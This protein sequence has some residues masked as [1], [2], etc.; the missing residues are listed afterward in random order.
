MFFLWFVDSR[1]FNGLKRW[2]ARRYHSH[3]LKDSPRL[4]ELQPNSDWLSFYHSWMEDQES[5]QSLGCSCIADIADFIIFH[6]EWKMMENAIEIEVKHLVWGWE[7]VQ[8][9]MF[10]DLGNMFSGRLLDG[11][12]IEF[13]GIGVPTV[14]FLPVKVVSLVRVSNHPICI[15]NQSQISKYMVHWC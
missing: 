2:S 9:D 8:R 12:A 15:G 1:C 6:L 11:S 14:R 13:A 3:I 5:F 10:Q 4:R 7:R